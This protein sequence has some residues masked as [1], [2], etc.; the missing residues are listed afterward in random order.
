MYGSPCAGDFN[1]YIFLVA[2]EP[3]VEFFFSALNIDIQPAKIRQ[4]SVC[5]RRSE[6]G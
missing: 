1:F 3:P 6:R 5:K 2:I 4:M